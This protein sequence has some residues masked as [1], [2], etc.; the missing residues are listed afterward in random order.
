MRF[1]LRSRQFKKTVAIIAIVLALAITVG[2]FGGF[3][4]PQAGIIGTITAPF[5]KLNNSIAGTFIDF[6][7]NFKSAAELSAQK[8]ELEAEISEL[9]GQLV[10]YYDILNQNEEYKKYLE[11]K[12][13]NPD[14]KFCPSMVTAVDP[15]DIFGG[16]TLDSGSINGV[17]LYDP[18]ITD[19]GLVGFI[20]E[21]GLTT[22]KVSTVLSPSLVC[23]AY[24]SRTNDA[25]A[26]SGTTELAL[27]NQTRFYNLPRTCS[28]AVGDIIV[29]SG[30]GVFP[31]KI[32]IGTVSNIASDPISSSLYAT[33][34]PA[35][36]FESL[37]NVMVI[38][39]FKGQGNELISGDE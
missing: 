4:A 12:E 39:D 6:A 26:L 17:S 23:G 2:L 35:V 16:F 29:T 33:I 20:T 34:T 36:D 30:S 15:D 37:K 9:K 10:D 18:V 32:I 8:E 28:V 22:S 13:Q 11:I 3:M 19:A 31:D 7:N 14:F 27:Q 1:F 25:G 38:T 21:V 5:Q 24:D